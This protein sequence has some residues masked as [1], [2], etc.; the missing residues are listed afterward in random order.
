MGAKKFFGKFATGSI[1][2]INIRSLQVHFRSLQI[3][4]RSLQVHFRSL[5]VYLRSLQVHFR[6]FQVH[7]GPFRYT[8]GLFRYTSGLF[9]YT[10]GLF[11][12]T[13]C[14]FRYTLVTFR[15]TLPVY[16]DE[17]LYISVPYKPH[18]YFCHVHFRYILNAVVHSVLSI[19]FTVHIVTLP[20]FSSSFPIYYSCT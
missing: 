11:R 10:S 15:Y 3:H 13:S 9:R 6:S 19:R 18:F 16:L 1:N 2:H 8:C 17:L 14:P 20:V 4:F 7:F 12:Y 5:Q